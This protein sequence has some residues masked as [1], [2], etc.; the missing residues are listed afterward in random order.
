MN[1]ENLC[2][3]SKENSISEQSTRQ[4]FFCRRERWQNTSVKFKITVPISRM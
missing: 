2:G 3:I 1:V 4:L